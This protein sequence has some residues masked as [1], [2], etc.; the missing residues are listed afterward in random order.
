MTVRPKHCTIYMRLLGFCLPPLMLFA[1]IL[2]SIPYNVR[3]VHAGGERAEWWAWRMTTDPIWESKSTNLT[4]S[5]A[6]GDIDNDGDLD[7]VAGHSSYAVDAARH[8]LPS[9]LLIGQ[10]NRLFLNEGGQLNPEPVWR[11]PLANTMSIALGDIDGDGDLDL[12]A[13]NAGK[14]AVYMNEGGQLSSQPVWQSTEDE[15]TRSIAL[16]DLNGDGRLELVAG[17][18]SSFGGARRNRVYEVSAAIQNG[19]PE[20]AGVAFGAENS[21]SWDLVLADFDNSGHLDVA[22]I[23]GQIYFGDGTGNFSEITPDT[24]I[25]SCGEAVGGRLAVG[26]L[27]QDRNLDIAFSGVSHI[28]Y[29]I[30]TQLSETPAKCDAIVPPKQGQHTLAVALADVNGD[31]TLEFSYG[32]LGGVAIYPTNA[33]WDEQVEPLW[34]SEDK[35]R[36]EAL[37]WGDIDGDGDVDLAVGGEG[38]PIRLY[39]NDALHHW[40]AQEE[41]LDRDGVYEGVFEFQNIGLNSVDLTSSDIY[42]PLIRL[43]GNWIDLDGDG[44]Y[45]DASDFG[46]DVEP[47]K[48]EDS[49]DLDSHGLKHAWGDLD[50]DG[51]LDL[52]VSKSMGQSDANGEIEAR[53][54]RLYRSDPETGI[55]EMDDS[56]IVDGQFAGVPAW[57][58][59]NGDGWL[60]LVVGDGRGQTFEEG[61]D[62]VFLNDNGSLE[63]DPTWVSSDNLPTNNVRL[64]DV[65]GDGD[66]D[67]IARG[68]IFQSEDRVYFNDAGQLRPN[69]IWTSVFD[70]IAYN[71][72][73][74]DFN[75]DGINDY[76]RGDRV[77]FVSDYDPHHPSYPFEHPFRLH[78]FKLGRLAPAATPAQGQYIEDGVVDFEYIIQGPI[79]RSYDVSGYFSV[80]NGQT[81]ADAIATSDTLTRS[82]P[83]T[84]ASQRNAFID[85][86]N[87]LFTYSWD[88]FSSGFTGTSDNVI[89]RLQVRPSP[90]PAAHSVPGLYQFGS[91]VAD[92]PPLRVRGKQVRVVSDD[93]AKIEGANGYVLR[94]E[95]SAARLMGSSMTG[96]PFVTNGSGFLNGRENIQEGDKLFATQAITQ[97]Y[98]IPPQLIFGE[99]AEPI[100]IDALQISAGERLDAFSA[101]MW[102]QPT[103]DTTSTLIALTDALT[104][105]YATLSDT[106]TIS[107]TILNKT[108]Q[109]NTVSLN[110]G[111]AHHIAVRWSSD[112]ENHN[113][114]V[115]VDGKK[116]L[117]G[118]IGFRST[119]PSESKLTIGQDFEGYMDEIRV[120]DSVRMPIT[121]TRFITSNAFTTSDDS[122]LVTL[123]PTEKEH[124]VGYW[125]ITADDD[126]ILH[127]HSGQANHAIRPDGVLVG[128]KPLFTIYNTSGVITETTVTS[129][130]NGVIMTPVTAGGVQTLTVSSQNRLILF[131]LDV[132]LEWDA[133]N[134]TLYLQQLNESIQR[135]S[136]LLYDI[137][138][139]QVALGQINLFFDKAYWGIADIAIASD[140]SLR[141]YAYIGG[142]VNQVVTEVTESGVGR[143]T[144]GQIRMGTSWDPYGENTADLGEE[145]SRALAHELAHYLLFLPDN[146]LG[147]KANAIGRVVCPGSFMTTTSDP[148]FT[149]FITRSQWDSEA[150]CQNT[151]AN[152]TTGRSDW[153][154]VLKYFPMLQAPAGDT[155]ID[156]PSDLLLAVTHIVPWGFA[157]QPLPWMVRNF[158]IRDSRQ[159]RL[160]LP[161]AQAFLIKTQGTHVDPN[162]PNSLDYLEDDVFIA[163]GS[164]TGGGDRL[165]VRGATDGDRLCVLD[166]NLEQPHSGCIETMSANIVAVSVEPVS[167]SAFPEWRPE[168]IAQATSANSVAITVTQALA[169]DEKMHVQVYP[170]HYRSVQGA[171]PVTT[172]DAPN[173][174]NEWSTEIEL[175]LAAYEIAV[176]VWVPADA[177]LCDGRRESCF[178]EAVTTFRLNPETWEPEFNYPEDASSE[179]PEP[180]VEL[181]IPAFG[182]ST[183][184]D[185]DRSG[186]GGGNNFGTGGSDRSGIGGGNSFGTGGSDRSGIGGAIFLGGSDRSG[187]GGAGFALLGNP[188]QINQ[189]GSDRSG[190]GGSDRSGIG[191]AGFAQTGGASNAL[192]A[193][194]WSAD[195]QVVIYNSAGYFAD[196]GVESLQA[197]ASVPRQQQNPWFVPVGQAYRLVLNNKEW[198]RFISFNFLQRE[199]PEGYEHALKILFMAEGSDS[200]EI[201]DDSRSF[202]ENLI[203][204]KLKHAGEGEDS[205]YL[206][207]VYVVAATVSSP[208]LES[209]W[210]LLAYT[211]PDS[212]FAFKNP[213]R[214]L[215][216][217]DQGLSSLIGRINY[218][219][220]AQDSNNTQPAITDFEPT[221][222]FSDTQIVLYP[223][224]VYWVHLTEGDAT[225]A[226]FAPPERQPDGFY[227][228]CG[229]RVD[230]ESR[231]DD[232]LTDANDDTQNQITRSGIVTAGSPIVLALSGLA[233]WWFRVPKQG[234]VVD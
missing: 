146:Y 70:E 225:Q 57:G 56:W 105:T 96:Q 15:F 151:L 190:I 198:E 134:D 207:G 75:R 52:A 59:I 148:S 32:H 173:H 11:S 224:S 232:R 136:A 221:E 110:D 24:R 152:I 54:T 100:V 147:I 87:N 102:L 43:I 177:N 189:G 97:A 212:R 103:G 35:R 215:G 137:T 92:T 71:N 218:I 45:E 171:A 140:N 164:P 31:R 185:S 126:A 216:C 108:I 191:G 209:G 153:E 34:E 211:M 86:P 101:E 228:D 37:A 201:L 231:S 51:W 122:L 160:R 120:W 49:L 80:D 55:L 58:D 106:T 112:Q 219:A 47:F 63:S 118:L 230:E 182:L 69:A 159:E 175:P 20:S 38:A 19:E 127:D 149:E 2:G 186:I 129:S 217:L 68:E 165:K 26:D 89:F 95:D 223:G 62:K 25:H 144:P 3:T 187:I 4:T 113:A 162:Q 203:V 167:T 170:L 174:V 104:L 99:D 107:L 21:G 169:D 109:T 119:L 178:R 8:P 18:P 233:L 194:M 123:E 39:R 67:M 131:D 135:A 46:T 179:E 125:R 200:W 180:L 61:Y 184:G 145:W 16:G 17:N 183:P 114:H 155:A 143:Y 124:L 9:D 12:A 65:D 206:N 121:N 22:T 197:L 196:N 81:W 23:Q 133:R 88:V 205:S 163:L 172:I 111:Q 195:A 227:P 161:D 79:Q 168:I 226:Y 72:L 36:V 48:F 199:V 166:G 40:S 193:P 13:G 90:V 117:S 1:L 33:L 115:F 76:E 139:G 202:P 5:L 60:D 181:L 77:R 53:T 82:L 84:W 176:R 150:G 44:D 132:S 10:S 27:T 98:R 29:N 213:D 6:W 158:D 28:A 157:E 93:G 142:V 94:A 138:D 234:S 208:D 73:P 156:G 64:L 85:E 222:T 220:D 210:N 116:I 41:D 229:A 214:R 14:N 7:L 66:L 83:I 204:A 128:Y 192:Y 141:P 30:A 91:M 130:T 50:N 188:N 78:L 154:T 74:T 42:S